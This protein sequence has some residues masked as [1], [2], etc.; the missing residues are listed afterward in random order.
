MKLNNLNGWMRF[1]ILISAIYFILV[2]SYAVLTFPKAENPIPQE[3]YKLGKVTFQGE[4]GFYEKDIGFVPLSS[5]QKVTYNGKRGFYSEEIGFIPVTSS[6]I[7]KAGMENGKW[8]NYQR[9]MERKTT[10]KRLKFVPSVFLFWLIPCL[11]LYASGRSIYWVYKG[12]KQKK[13]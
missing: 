4:K 6:D 12:F 10:A 3:N 11:A 2:T 1:W 9:I 7:S 8:E 13:T 5:M